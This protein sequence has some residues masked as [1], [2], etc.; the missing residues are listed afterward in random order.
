MDI[1]QETTTGKMYLK[2]I[3]NHKK[4]AHTM[5]LLYPVSTIYNIDFFKLKLEF[6][7]IN[8]N[9]VI[10]TKKI[11]NIVCGSLKMNAVLAS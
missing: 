5:C 3:L 11:V 10:I 1:S 9:I 6:D 2:P 8:R 4:F 7:K